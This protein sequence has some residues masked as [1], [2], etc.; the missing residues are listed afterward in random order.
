[1]VSCFEVSEGYLENYLNWLANSSEMSLIENYFATFKAKLMNKEYA[2]R[3][4]TIEI[5]I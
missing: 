5:V 3:T 2:T 4:D 1:M